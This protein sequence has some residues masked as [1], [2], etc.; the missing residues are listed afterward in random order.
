MFKK[1]GMSTRN[2]T[3]EPDNDGGVS[4]AT[5]K[6][7]NASCSLRMFSIWRENRKK[8]GIGL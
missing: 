6:G 2:R 8:E 1:G 7:E 3:I 4:T 5:C